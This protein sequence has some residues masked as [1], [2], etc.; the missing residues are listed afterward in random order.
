MRRVPDRQVVCILGMGRAGTSLVA[1]VLNLM[2]VDLGPGDHIMGPAAS[3]PRGH[4]E[5]V[6]LVNLNDEILATFGGSWHEPPAFP[7]DWHRSPVLADQRQ[8]ARA[9]IEADFA[10]ADLWGWKD[11]RTSLTLPFWQDILPAMMYVICLRSPLATAQSLHRRDGFTLEKGG[12]LWLS[13]VTSAIRHTRGHRRLF[14]FYEDMIDAWQVEVQRLAVFLGKPELSRRP[15]ILRAIEDFLDL[16]LEHHRSTLPQAL[17]D[18]STPYPAQALCLVLRSQVN[19]QSQGMRGPNSGNEETALALDTFSQLSLGLLAH[20]D[21]LHAEADAISG[22]LAE[23]EQAALSL[24]EERAALER[25]LAE[26]EGRLEALEVQ[27][28]ERERQVR[29]MEQSLSWRVT[30][31]LRHAKR[32]WRRLF[33]RAPAE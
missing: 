13:Y 22:R 10:K 28:S 3:N 32:R 15:D 23:K 18:T 19:E 16:S 5:H 12:R 20:L 6:P 17:F 30:A 2:G 9:I 4:W 27:L 24:D 8:R 29:G 21:A 26:R 7:V 33:R 31:P 14:V 25:E 1:R 11:P